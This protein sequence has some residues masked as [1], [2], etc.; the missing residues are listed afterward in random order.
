M[1]IDV[2]VSGLNT[3]VDVTMSSQPD[4]I[5]VDGGSIVIIEDYDNLAH[6][7][8]I[9]SV[10]LSGNKTSSQI[11]VADAIHTHTVSDVTDFPSLAT[12]ATTGDYDDLLNKPTIPDAVSV[13]QIVSTGTNIADIDIGGTTTHLYAPS[14]GGGA[15]AFVAEFNVTTYADVKDAYDN[16]AILV[17][18]V[19]DSGN[20]MTL[21]LVYFDVA[22]EIFYFAF[23]T[24]D[25][26]Y[27]TQLS[28][29]D[30]WGDGQFFFAST[31]VATQLADGLMSAL[32]KQK[33]D[34]LSKRNIWYGTCS[35][36][37]SQSP[38]AITTASGDFSLTAGNMLVVKFSNTNSLSSAS[39]QVDGGTSKSV[40]QLDGTSNIAN[41]WGGGE[42]VMFAYD[43]TKFILLDQST[44]S[45]TQYGIT[46]LNNTV[47]STSTSEAATANAVKSA[48]DHGG[49][50]SVNGSTGAVT[51]TVPTNVSD[52]NNDSGFTAT[53]ITRHTT[54]GTNI[55]DLTID[56]TTTKL[57]APT[58]GGGGGI[59]DVEVDGTSVVTGGVAEIDLTG[60]SDVGHTH[61][62]SA[63]TDFPSLATVATS[64]SYNDLLNKPTI[65]TVNDATLTIQKNGTT[66][67]S[68]T[69]NASSNVTANITVP[70]DTG[71]LTNGAGFITGY[72]ETDPIFTASAAYG[73]SSSDISAWNG[74][75][76]FSGSY[77]DLTDKPTLFSGDYNDLTNKPTIPTVPTNISSFVNDS[78]YITGYT[79]T[80]PVFSA[81]AASGITSSDISAWNGKSDFSGDYDDLYNKPTIL[82][83]DFDDAWSDTGRGYESANLS[84]AGS[85]Y[86]KVDIDLGAI[87]TKH[88]I[89]NGFDISG[90]GTA[91]IHTLGHYIFQSGGHWYAAIK[92]RN[93][94]TSAISSFSVTAY[95]AWI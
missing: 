91:R 34:G 78:G 2:T 47:T 26:W 28:N 48:Y 64:G 49:V 50:T 35:T 52:L 68:F 9:N 10:T 67:N 87:G 70:T 83:I 85:T 13:T 90:S 3:V 36:S 69:A 44:A 55:A 92:M 41:R 86:V 15:T 77:T 7:P 61:T 84:L 4:P 16:D 24:S 56:G 53:S 80:D 19:D 33:L 45:T 27:L 93:D 60:K 6:K 8:S 23:P 66:V 79:E 30:G 75:S 37:A 58:G 17:C 57:Y 46:K 39:L 65:P 32:D 94:N 42:V 54:T 21:Q 89:F 1:A 71:D 51:V 14:G 81:S 76:D 82:T 29:A 74:K 31:D 38:K 11:G 62:T 12:V 40:Y 88:P 5:D 18:T 73:I 25:G 95:I 59:T 43:G 72:T 22:N 20:T 63:I